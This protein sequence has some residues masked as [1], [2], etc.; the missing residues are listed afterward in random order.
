[1]SYAAAMRHGVKVPLAAMSGSKPLAQLTALVTG[2]A[3]L[4]F[5]IIRVGADA[6][7]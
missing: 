6:L 1:M 5:V 3:P 7:E 4:D 2:A